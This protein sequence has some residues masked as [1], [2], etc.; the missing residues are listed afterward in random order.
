MSLSTA[1]L[2]ITPMFQRAFDLMNESGR[3]ILLTGKAGTGKSTLLQYFRERTSKRV[4]VLAPTGV[5]A[6]NIHGQTIHSFFGFR[7]NITPDRARK[8]GQ[9]A[10][11]RE[12]KL[13]E[14]LDALVLDEISMVRADLFECVDQFLR[15]ALAKPKLAFG[16]VQLIMIGDLYQLP[17]VI[18]TAERELF[19]SVY[20]GPYFFHAPIFSQ[21]HLELIELDKIFR[22]RDAEFIALLNAVRNNSLTARD[23][24]ALNA[25]HAPQTQR[26]RDAA[27]ITLTTTN[28]AAAAINAEHLRGLRGKTESFTGIMQGSFPREQAP[29]D[30]DLELKIGAQV[31]LLNNDSEKRW[32]N[33]TI[34]TITEMWRDD[35]ATTHDETKPVKLRNFED[36]I[37]FHDDDA[38]SASASEDATCVTVQLE[39]G[40]RVEVTPFTWNAYRYTYD[41]QSQTL[42][43]ESAGSFTQLPMRLAWAVTIHKSQGKTFD[44]VVID[45]GRGAFAT[46]QTYV[47]LSRCRTFEGIAL[48]KPLKPSDVRVDPRVVKFLTDLERAEFLDPP[49]VAAEQLTVVYDESERERV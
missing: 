23:L 12:E 33:G 18:P 19:A 49:S 47:A 45:I 20:A 9:T 17:P 39:S 40:E 5:A 6:I 31:M 26:G 41:E 43:T 1:A 48:S 28:D 37:T 11:R 44:R 25:R 42:D 46:G 10:R 35:R 27:A 38:D 22:Q 13:Y 4:A 14:K 16:G 24:A 2:E 15:A 29:T 34:G 21:L 7:P 30:V 36:L 3:H 32:V 8:A